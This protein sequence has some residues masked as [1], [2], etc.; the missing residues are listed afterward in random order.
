MLGVIKL[1][2]MRALSVYAGGMLLSLWAPVACDDGDSAPAGNAGSN[3]GGETGEAGEAG[4]GNSSNAGN[5]NGGSSGSGGGGDQCPMVAFIDPLDGTKLTEADDEGAGT[6]ADSCS[7]GFQYDV[8]AATSAADGTKAVLYS[9]SNQV[10]MAT[11]KGGVVTF[12]K[13]QLSI[14]T[15]VLK[16]QVGSAACTP[17]EASVEVSCKGLPTCD[18]TKPIVSPTHPVLNGVPVA[19]GGDRVSAVGSPYQVAFDVTTNI[20]DGRPV[21]L[22]IND[23]QL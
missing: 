20:A 7:D 1:F 14:G 3:S 11:V 23:S 10:A 12:P 18:I 13:A 6:N 4:Q 21:S 16:V 17:A 22:Q 15:D 8:K 19:Q 2:R 5:G 9:G